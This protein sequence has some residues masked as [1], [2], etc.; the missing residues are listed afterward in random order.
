MRILIIYI[1]LFL[2]GLS[3]NGCTETAKPKIKP[4]Q[5]FFIGQMLDQINGRLPKKINSKDY[6]II[7]RIGDTYFSPMSTVLC[8]PKENI[9]KSKFECEYFC[10]ND[11]FYPNIYTEFPEILGYRFVLENTHQSNVSFEKLNKYDI[12]GLQ[13]YIDE[14]VH[15]DKSQSAK[16]ANKFFITSNTEDSLFALDNNSN[17]LVRNYLISLYKQISPSEYYN[18]ATLDNGCEFD[19][20][21]Y[22]RLR[23]LS[24][25]DSLKFKVYINE[26]GE[27]W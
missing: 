27:N 8:L 19:T 23:N 6:W 10:F 2:F 14:K 15:N 20:K 22:N 5:Q 9:S 4:R 13:N 18:S 16:C 17:L 7:Y 24:K 1:T 21:L 11:S 3:M 25:H 26:V 12:E